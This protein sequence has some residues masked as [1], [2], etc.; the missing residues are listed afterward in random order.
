[1]VFLKFDVSFFQYVGRVS[2]TPGRPSVM[3]HLG[4]LSFGLLLLVMY[5]IYSLG[6]VISLS[7][8]APLVVNVVNNALFTYH[9]NIIEMFPEKP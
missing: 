6:I 9:A 2:Y 8:V 3:V 4:N 5:G 1:M 7:A